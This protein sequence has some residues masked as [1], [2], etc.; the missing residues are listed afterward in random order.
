MEGE[1][2]WALVM[3]IPGLKLYLRKPGCSCS[4]H[5][6]EAEERGAPNFSILKFIVL[7]FSVVS[8][9]AGGVQEKAGTENCGDQ[10]KGTVGGR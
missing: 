5:G 7:P 4:V 3:F 9:L 1:L 6:A 10:Q 2:L 8:W